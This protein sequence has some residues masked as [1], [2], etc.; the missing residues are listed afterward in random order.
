MVGTRTQLSENVVFSTTADI[1]CGFIS[2]HSRIGRIVLIPFFMILYSL[3]VNDR[4]VIKRLCHRGKHKQMY[5]S[6][7]SF[8]EEVFLEREHRVFYPGAGGGRDKESNS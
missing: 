2:N 6:H 4:H 8:K 5:I 3:S 1:L 7:R